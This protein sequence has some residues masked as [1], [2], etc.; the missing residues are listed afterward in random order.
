MEYGTMPT[1]AQYYKDFIDAKVDLIKEP[2]QCCPFH[3]EKTPSFSYMP[4]R[5][6]W[7]CFG[8]C[9]VRGADV[10]KMHQMKFHLNTREEAEESLRSLYKCPK[11]EET[12]LIEKRVIINESDVEYQSLVNRCIMLANTPEKWV[13]LDELMTYYPPEILDLQDLITRWGYV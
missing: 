2:K 5:G 1:V 13:E 12:R 4:Q 11:R 9:K 6:V 10:I 7:S 3:K 8:A